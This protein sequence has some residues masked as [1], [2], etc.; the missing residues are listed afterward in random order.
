MSDTE[1]PEEA[2]EVYEEAAGEAVGEDT[3][4]QDA[5]YE[6]VEK[7]TKNETPPSFNREKVLKIVMAAIGFIILFAFV[8]NAVNENRK[9]N[10][11]NVSDAFNVSV[12][13]SIR[14]ERDNA[15]RP[16]GGGA[17]GG[18]GGSFGELPDVEFVSLDDPA[19]TA[20]A[21]YAST[22]Y[23][24]GGS[25]D[26]PANGGPPEG[27]YGQPGGS[28]G[29]QSYPPPPQQRYGGGG[30]GGGGNVRR[31]EH[32]PLI[33]EVEGSLFN[34]GQTGQQQAALNPYNQPYGGYE[35]YM[36]GGVPVDAA[37]FQ[38]PQQ[39]PP[40]Q[41][42][43]M[44]D[45]KKD[46]YNGAENA[47]TGRN[48]YYLGDNIIWTGAVIPGVLITG[49]NTD[50][51]GD[52]VGRI[53]SNIYDSRTGKNLLLPQGT[54]LV[55]RYNSAVS[56]A[57]SRVQI[58]WEHLIRP[59]GYMFDLEGMNGV[60][61][62]GVSGQAGDYHENWFQY[63]K[64]AGI[65]AMFTLANAKVTEVAGVKLSEDAAQ[66]NAQLTAQLGGNIINRAL[67]IQPT[68]TVDSGEKINI[69]I[70]KPIYLP[71]VAD[72]PVTERYTRKKR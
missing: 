57:Q 16:D 48:G 10:K 41:A 44:Q 14:R 22:G 51:P 72:Y 62:K 36:N 13:D 12:P 26:A 4:Y 47:V 33:P 25:P 18:G 7:L 61:A 21:Y 1:E 52:V 63:L 39:Q 45:D 58:V 32:S 30:S 31:P 24:T 59:D 43:N 50:L 38:Y 35:G 15:L 64:A 49:I 70:N 8:I 5:S 69:M 19:G 20:S 55:A 37:Y 6:D 71:P 23:R 65:I 42:Q 56:Y 11:N 40:Y 2:A 34:S 46:F 29:S 53:T 68:I 28:P 9:K 54:I 66:A 27:V 17:D 67:D 60:D 3:S